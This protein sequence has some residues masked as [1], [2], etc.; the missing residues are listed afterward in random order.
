MLVFDFTPVTILF[1]A[2]SR[3]PLIT[4]L[5]MLRIFFTNMTLTVK[6]VVKEGYQWEEVGVYHHD[7]NL[8]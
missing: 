1:C 4:Q 3:K 6:W 7:L 8:I 2:T 5:T